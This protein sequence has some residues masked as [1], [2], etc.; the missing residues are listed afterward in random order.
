MVDYDGGGQVK[1]Y[2]GRDGESQ[3]RGCATEVFKPF[4]M[5][6]VGLL[7]LVI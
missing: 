1:G 2:S 5:S 4:Q 6:L 3:V 7:I